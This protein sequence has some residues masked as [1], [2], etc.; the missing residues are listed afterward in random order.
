MRFGRG[1]ISAKVAGNRRRC[2]VNREFNGLVG[3]SVVARRAGDGGNRPATHTGDT[4][5]LTEE[6]PAFRAW[7]EQGLERSGPPPGQ[8]CGC[9]ECRQRRE[10]GALQTPG[11]E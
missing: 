4:G 3:E 6:W 2:A 11:A 1:P 8:G 9:E 5:S 7:V 10:P